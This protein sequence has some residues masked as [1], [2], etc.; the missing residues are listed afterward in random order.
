MSNAQNQALPTAEIGIFGGSGF[1]QFLDNPQAIQMDTPYGPT[2]CDIMLAEVEGRKVAFL[3]RHGKNHTIPPH[4]VNYRA[5]VW[6]FKQLGCKHVISPCAVGS[7]QKDVKPG[8]FVVLSQYVDRTNSRKDTFFDG[9]NIVHTSAADPYCEV[10]RKAAIDAAQACEIEYH[11]EGTVVV[12]QGPRFS[13][14]SESNW[15]RGQGWEVIN[16][17]QYPEVH[18]VKELEMNACGIALVTDYDTGLPGIEPVSHEEVLK[19]MEANSGKLRK[20]L[21][22]MVKRIPQGN[23]AWAKP[24]AVIA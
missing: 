17:S 9:P 21:F 20:V 4:L 12:I 8:S 5:N 3:P 23:A 13:T 6:A 16:M 18:L 10:L 7:L 1:Y 22:E 19:V 24:E 2:S 11:K 14:R 15:F